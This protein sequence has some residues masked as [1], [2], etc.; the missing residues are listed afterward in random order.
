[1]KNTKIAY[2]SMEIA[3]SDE[4]P[5]Y[6]G[7]LGVLAADILLAAADKEKPLVGISLI[8]HRDEDQKKAFD[9]SKF[10]EKLDKTIKVEIEDREVEVLIYK[11]EAEGKSG[12]KITIYF[13][14]T[15]SENNSAGDKA[16][17]QYL[18]SSDGYIRLAQEIVL[19]VGGVRALEIVEPETEF[20]YHM[21]EGHSALLTLELLRRKNYAEKA[22]SKICTFTNHTPVAAG[23]DYF[24]YDLAYKIAGKLL[25]SNIK[26]L[27][28]PS[29]LGLTELAINLSRISNSVSEKHH[30]VCGKMFPGKN[31][32]NVTNG[33]YHLRWVG[34]EFAKLYD[35]YLSGWRENPSIFERAVEILPDEEVVAAKQA[36]KT[37]LIAWINENPSHFIFKDIKAEDKFDEKTLTA[38][39]ARRTVSYK[40]TDLIFQ[41]VE[42]LCGLGP[43]K[44]QL[45]FASSW[46]QFGGFGVSMRA[47]IEEQARKLRG[48]IKIV[49]LPE[50]TL[51]IARK[52]ATGSDIWINNPV[53]PLEASGTSGMKAALNGGMNVSILDGWWIEGFHKNPRSG[54]AFGETSEFLQPLKRDEADAIELYSALEEVLNCYYNRK[55]NWSDRMKEAISLTSFFNTYRVL[56][57]YEKNIWNAS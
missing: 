45:I 38:V 28:T 56:E 54:W 36:E 17:T 30:G 33:I 55:K 16:I 49:I 47:K 41:N 20:A 40:R 35:K 6:Y 44:I 39:F 13:L 2:F 3:L 29:K 53:P 34:T 8:Y 11:L 14:S 32:A 9:P 51:E 50:Y 22:V 31:F 43:K 10:M 1:M 15:N 18:Y 7:G 37:K 57:E 46:I 4:I 19:G 42:R 12:K 26:N 24:E 27:S 48:Q 25:P 5:N 21:N 23:H 52:L